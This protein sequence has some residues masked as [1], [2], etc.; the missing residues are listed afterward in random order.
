MRA[1]PDDAGPNEPDF[2]DACP[3]C[4]AENCA[5]GGDMLD[6]SYLTCGKPEC[7]LE[8]EQREALDRAADDALYEQWKRDAEAE[9]E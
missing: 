8:M 1:R 5:D 2:P 3:V 9:A 7:I 4:G 6:P